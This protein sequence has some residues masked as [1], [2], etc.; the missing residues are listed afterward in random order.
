MVLITAKIDE[1]VKS[2]KVK[3]DIRKTRTCERCKS[4]VPLA[5]VRLYPQGENRN[6]LLCGECCDVLKNKNINTSVERKVVRNIYQPREAI[7]IQSPT[8]IQPPT[9]TKI[10]PNT[11]NKHI[12]NRPQVSCVRCNYSFTISEP[13]SG[14][15][16][17]LSCPYCGKSDR[18]ERIKI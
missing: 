4:Q 7:K 16:S 3:I 9:A 2:E 14:V 5:N 18:M 1:K 6:L 13:K 10:L 15:T 17:R 8:K 12:L 11:D